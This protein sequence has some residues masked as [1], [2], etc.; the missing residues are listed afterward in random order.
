MSPTTR[1]HVANA[2]GAVPNLFAANPEAAAEYVAALHRNAEHALAANPDNPLSH[3][4][5][6]VAEAA[7]RELDRVTQGGA[8]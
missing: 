8:L 2:R 3:A 6:R 7:Q 4:H 5:A 1:L